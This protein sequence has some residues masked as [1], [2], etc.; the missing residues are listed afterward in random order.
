MPKIECLAFISW[1]KNT[2]YTNSNTKFTWTL[3]DINRNKLTCTIQFTTRVKMDWDV[4]IDVC[5]NST[6]LW[7]SKCWAEDCGITLKIK[8]YEFRPTFYTPDILILGTRV[9]LQERIS[10]E[11]TDIW[12]SIKCD[13]IEHK[14]QSDICSLFA[15]PFFV[16]HP[17]PKCQNT[18]RVLSMYGM[19]VILIIIIIISLKCT[20]YIHIYIH[21][22][23]YV[24]NAFLNAKV[25]V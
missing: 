13:D 5:L 23:T 9:E 11:W 20:P 24:Y 7:I 15:H 17:R 18:R 10:E 22:H 16:F 3:N 21:I 8:V 12:L 25:Q 19:K 2:K 1:C 4:Y 6:Q 14:R